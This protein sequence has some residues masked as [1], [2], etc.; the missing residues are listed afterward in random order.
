MGVH[1][2][3][4]YWYLFNFREEI[5]CTLAPEWDSTEQ[6]DPLTLRLG[7]GMAE[8]TRYCMHIVQKD[9]ILYAYCTKTFIYYCVTRSNL[10]PAIF[11]LWDTFGCIFIHVTACVPNHSTQQ[12]QDLNPLPQ[13]HGILCCKSRNTYN[14]NHLKKAW[15]INSAP[16]PCNK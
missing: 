1:L 7:T 3:V 5:R 10:R 13:N 12:H 2:T 4:M 8:R 6:S 15:L 16:L 11:G 9:Y 14:V